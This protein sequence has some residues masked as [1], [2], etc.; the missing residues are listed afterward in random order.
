[1]QAVPKELLEEATKVLRLPLFESRSR[2]DVPAR[3]LT[4][5]K[6]SKTSKQT[7]WQ[8]AHLRNVIFMRTL[9]SCGIR[10]YSNIVP[11][12]LPSRLTNPFANGSVSLKPAPDASDE[13]EDE[14]DEEIDEP[15]LTD[16]EQVEDAKKDTVNLEDFRTQY[17]QDSLGKYN[18]M[19]LGIHFAGLA[20]DYNED[21]FP[22]QEFFNEAYKWVIERMNDPK[23]AY[24]QVH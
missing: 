10:K 19:L 18:K 11:V 22:G 15:N 1:M 21:S 3:V 20:K 5:T 14:E 7:S 24:L 23:H 8:A 13:E 9:S 2:H 17:L 6:T 4:V 12:L 16:K